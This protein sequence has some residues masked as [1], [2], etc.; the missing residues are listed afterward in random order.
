MGS[1]VDR[2][3]TG[4]MALDVALLLPEP[5]RARALELSDATWRRGSRGVR[6]DD[7]H[8]PHVTLTQQFVSAIQLD[9]VLESI[10]RVVRRFQPLTL[11]V[12]GGAKGGSSIWMALERTPALVELHQQL[13]DALDGFERRT[14][15]A[16]AFFEGDAR[17]KDVAWVT[18]YRTKAS[19]EWFR[20]HVTLGHGSQ[21][22]AIP[23]FAFDAT[24]VAACHLGRFC[25]CRCVFRSWMLTSE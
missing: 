5:I 20:P 3:R 8:L 1:R 18:G 21:P 12:N 9:G 17:Q 6:L 25:S 4:L 14:G 19:F 24:T 11:S 13:M 15:T 22:P 7:S 10:D 2:T 23:P 16:A